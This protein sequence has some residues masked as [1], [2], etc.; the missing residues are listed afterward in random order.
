MIQALEQLEAPAHVVGLASPNHPDQYSFLR[1]LHLRY[2]HIPDD[3]QKIAND[4]I[5]NWAKSLGVGTVDKTHTNNKI[6]FTP[7]E[8]LQLTQ[9]VASIISFDREYSNDNRPDPQSSLLTAIAS[10]CDNV[11]SSD[12]QLF[13]FDLQWVVNAANA[14]PNQFTPSLDALQV[15]LEQSNA[16]LLELQKKDDINFNTADLDNSLERS[17]K[18]T[19]NMYITSKIAS[20]SLNEFSKVYNG[21]FKELSGIRKPR[22]G[23]AGRLSKI[24]TP[25]LKNINMLM[26]SIQ[27]SKNCVNRINN[28]LEM[29]EKECS[30]SNDGCTVG[31]SGGSG[32]S[33]SSSSSSSSSGD[34]SDTSMVGRTN[35]QTIRNDLCSP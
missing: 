20:K 34:G 15:E 19:E 27:N 12:C 10:D 11:F 23:H 32:G 14:S 13:P 28:V 25:K 17:L 21:N 29:M 31:S 3:G 2:L 6:H 5:I 4:T 26:K 16:S 7:K 22:L 18:A 1:Y 9:T 8:I 30:H 35:H 33:S 24:T